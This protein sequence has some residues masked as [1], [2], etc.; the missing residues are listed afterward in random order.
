MEPV[1]TQQQE[2]ELAPE[3]IQP[4]ESQEASKPLPRD[5]LLAKAKAYRDHQGRRESA[6][7]QLTMDVD[8]LTMPPKR[9]TAKSPFDSDNLDVPAYLRRRR[10][11]LESSDQSE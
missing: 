2:Q 8:D 4:V 11:E 9:E 10:G 6:P 3:R 7:E 5:I 1:E